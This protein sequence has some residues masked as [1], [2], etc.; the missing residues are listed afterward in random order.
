M[1]RKKL[2]KHFKL[3]NIVKTMVLATA[4]ICGL[5]AEA[6]TAKAAITATPTPTPFP[7]DLTGTPPK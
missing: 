6:G 3:R 4:V 5:T 1:I 7:R 2:M